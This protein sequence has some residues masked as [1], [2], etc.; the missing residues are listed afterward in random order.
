MYAATVRPGIAIVVQKG[1]Y[2]L[3]VGTHV[4]L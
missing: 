1:R 3:L 2:T 4:M